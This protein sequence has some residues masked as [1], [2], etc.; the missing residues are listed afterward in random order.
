MT[1]GY[2]SKY[3]SVFKPKDQGKTENWNAII[4]MF[5]NICLF[6]GHMG[7]NFTR[8]Y[9]SRYD[10]ILYTYGCICILSIVNKICISHESYAFL[11][12]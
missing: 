4:A 3:T 2:N 1:L 5:D 11:I 12:S 8:L 10:I 6:P 7:F 9:K